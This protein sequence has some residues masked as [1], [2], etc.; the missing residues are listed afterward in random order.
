MLMCVQYIKSLA[1]W[2]TSDHD[3]VHSNHTYTEWGRTM[4][5]TSHATEPHRHS[6]LFY[7]TKK[8][9]IE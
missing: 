2:L 5:L 8:V 6:F 9:E 4:Q 3:L 1:R 7:F